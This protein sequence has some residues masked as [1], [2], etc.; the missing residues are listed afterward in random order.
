MKKM[1]T[2]IAA[3]VL[4]SSIASLGFASDTASAQFLK[5]GAGARATALGEAVTSVVNDVTAAYWNPAGLTQI[6]T[7]EVSFMQKSSLVGSNYQY[8]G[9][10]FPGLRHTVALSLYRMDYGSIERYSAADVRDGSFSADSL[11]AAVSVGTKISANLSWGLSAK[12]IQESIETEKASGFAGDLGLLYHEDQT[13]FGVAVQHLGAGLKFVQDKGYLPMTVRA[14]ASHKFLE[15]K[16]Q[17]SLD[18]SK[19]VDNNASFHTGLEYNV[20]TLFVLRGGYKVTPGNTLDVGGLTGICGGFGVNFR[21]F[22][23][24]YA[25]VPFGDLGNTQSVSVVVRF[26]SGR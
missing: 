18:V 8:A 1:Q 9:G 3:V 7:P 6:H 16:V 19:P 22:T 12:L 10:A 13:S 23:L 5:L 25:F 11:S 4:S 2:I 24:D 20:N 21:S 14:G 15:K 17:A 26:N